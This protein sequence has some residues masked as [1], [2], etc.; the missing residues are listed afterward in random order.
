MYIQCN[1]EPGD[2][3]NTVARELVKI[4]ATTGVE[5]SAVFNDISVYAKPGEPFAVV[6]DRYYRDRE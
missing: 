5:A 6:L 1:S 3:I 4:A 2:S